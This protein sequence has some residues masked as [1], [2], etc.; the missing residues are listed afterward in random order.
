[1]SQV[2][3]ALAEFTPDSVTVKLLHGVFRAIPFAPEMP[4][5]G[6]LADVVAHLRPGAGAAGLAAV[7]AAAED[8]SITDILW[9]AK[10]MDMGDKGYAVFTGISSAVQFFFGD[11]STA[12]DTDVQQRNDAVLKSIGIAYMALKAYPGTLTERGEA[13]R[14]SPAGQAI[15]MYYGA[16]EVALPFAD[17]AMLAGGAI[18]GD[19]YGKYGKD[20]LGKLLAMG[21]A[22][23]GVGEAEGMLSTISGGL[24]KVVDH[25]RG[26][27]EPIANAARPFLPKIATGGDVLAGVVANAVD[28]LPVYRYLG[29]R[30]AA[31]AAVRRALPQ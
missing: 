26:Y 2:E 13:F 31:E 27:V 5:Y 16:C 22:E 6:S 19:L 25:T 10:V 21:G 18:V 4:D 28:V 1:M 3:A 8:P 29:A 20:Q 11:R 14:T 15:A 7:R 24:S 9:M 17:N 23:H 30:L 12:L